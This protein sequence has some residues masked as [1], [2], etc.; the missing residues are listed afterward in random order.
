MDWFKTMNACMRLCVLQAEIPGLSADLRAMHLHLI[1]R[2][3]GYP[4]WEVRA[5]AAAAKDAG[6]C[7]HV[8]RHFKGRLFAQLAE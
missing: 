2:G 7:T 4:E 6:S 3:L 1:H 5:A 8:I